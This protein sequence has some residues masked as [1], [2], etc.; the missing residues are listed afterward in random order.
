MV[1]VITILLLNLRVQDLWLLAVM[2]EVCPLITNTIKILKERMTN[3][4]KILQKKTNVGAIVGG[5]IAGLLLLGFI[6]GVACKSEGFRNWDI[7]NLFTIS[8]ATEVKD[9]RQNLKVL[10]LKM[11]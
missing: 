9:E 2:V 7:K 6:G 5:T 1:G 11:M 4:V 8:T 10:N 3:Y